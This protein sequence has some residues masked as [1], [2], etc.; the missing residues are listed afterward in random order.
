MSSSRDSDDYYS[1]K[2][3]DPHP[4][5]SAGAAQTTGKL[6]DLIFR[7][8]CQ[9]C[10][11]FIILIAFL[12]VV[13]LVRDSW[14]LLMN[15]SKYQVFTGTTWDPN[16]DPPKY[17]IWTFVY[18]TLASSLIAMLLAVPFG[19]GAAA[20]LSE[21]ASPGVRKITS[22]LVELLASI[23][24][25]V[26][27]FWGLKFLSPYLNT[28]YETLGLESRSSGQGI[29][30]A[31]IILA[32]MI[33]P[34]IT[35]ISFDVL[36]AVPSAQRQASLALGA[37]RWQMI[38]GVALPYARPGIIAACFL[39]LGRAIGETMAV[40]MLIGNVRHIKVALTATGDSMASV[41]ANQLNEA[42]SDHHVS[43][44]IAMGLFLLLITVTMN[45]IAR[46][47]VRRM[48]NPKRI[49][50]K[51]SPIT[52]QAG[53]D[54]THTKLVF[55]A[56]ARHRAAVINKIMTVVLS[57][58]TFLT[59]LP[60][61]LILGYI[62]VKGVNA[63]NWSFFTQLPANGGLL[64]AIVYSGIMVALATIV[65]VPIA[66][67]TAIYLHEYH[68]SW[69]VKPVR[70][71]AEI[72]GGIPSII[73]GVFVYS[74]CVSPTWIVD[75]FGYTPLQAS[76]MFGFS[77]WSGVV[78]LAIMMLPV[79]IRS[80][81]ESMRLVP[82]SLRQASYALGASRYQT[83]LRVILPAALPAIVT[84]I[85]LASGRIAGETAP[86]LM[87]A[88]GSEFWPNGL[89]DKAPFL[90]YYIYTYALDS[91]PDLQRQ[92]WAAAFVL[93]TFVLVM[94]ICIR[95]A[96]GRRLVSASRAD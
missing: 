89:T 59:V 84:G 35:A 51:F 54:G 44:L 2:S 56:K 85:L 20:Y 49:T 27:G 62:C 26:Y 32:I 91:S 95:L 60:L 76:R 47:L 34:Y 22:F 52:L 45:V 73:I 66:L 4:L 29:V 71:I 38:W 42:S 13:M 5:P 40:T 93:L 64:H 58:M 74:M 3:Q 67:C 63:L 70:F 79:V 55:S 36:R 46:L 14:P 87:T 21:I 10:A 96:S 68:R 81:E 86:L 28:L 15:A 88:N 11:I 31:G 80:A 8:I 6:G 25:V 33:L 24:S 75:L 92:A 69:L 7:F 83:V 61:F 72:L 48:S 82:G 57:I 19:V 41:I 12:L 77:A 9:S 53:A 94:N 39:A 1:P 37:S 50:R 16:P 78:A 30:A 90:P 23:P 65:A 43:A 18:G 17:G